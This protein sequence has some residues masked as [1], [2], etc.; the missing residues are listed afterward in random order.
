MSI[1]IESLS[2]ID[3]WL[4]NRTVVCSRNFR[5]LAKQWSRNANVI[6]ESL[7]CFSLFT[8][9]KADPTFYE[10]NC[11]TRRRY[12]SPRVFFRPYSRR[13]DHSMPFSL[14]NASED[15]EV[16]RERKQVKVSK[17]SFSGSTSNRVMAIPVNHSSHGAFRP[18]EQMHVHSPALMGLELN[19][20]FAR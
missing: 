18:N 4:Q 15:G 20:A 12:E 17:R 9:V 10:F 5:S 7:S 3:D 2:Y 16:S 8:F 19:R 1:I 14:E 11:D 6:G 13:T